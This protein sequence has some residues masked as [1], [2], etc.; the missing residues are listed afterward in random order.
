LTTRVPN[1][2]AI[3]SAIVDRVDVVT[4]PGQRVQDPGQYVRTVVHTAHNPESATTPPS[5]GFRYRTL[6]ASSLAISTRAR[7]FVIFATRPHHQPLP[8]R[9]LTTGFRDVELEF[10]NGR[11]RWRAVNG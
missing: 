2:A 3:Y 9:L 11:Q 10:P 6:P 8:D 5:S 7:T 4:P 1:F